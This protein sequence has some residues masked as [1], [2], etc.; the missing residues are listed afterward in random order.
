M[1]ATAAHPFA[2]RARIWLG[3]T[4]AVVTIALCGTASHFGGLAHTHLPA[5]LRAAQ[6]DFS[7]T[8]VFAIAFA[9]VGALIVW[10]RP[11]NRIGWVCCAIGLLWGV[12]EFVLGYFS[13]AAYAPHP[14]IPGVHLV[15]WLVSWIWV[16][17]VLLTFVLLPFLFPDGQ[18]VSPRWWP[19]VWAAVASMTLVA[20]GSITHLTVLSL[21][22]QFLSLGCAV[23][24]PVTLVIRYRR[25]GPDER[26]Q[27]KWFAGAALLLAGLAVAATVVSVLVYHSPDVVFN[28]VGGTVLPLGLT[29]LAAA[30]GISVL[31]YQLYDIGLFLRRALV[32]AALV[33]LIGVLYLVLVV[34][35]GTRI[36][37]PTTDRAIPFVVAA[38]L[39]LIFQPVRIRLQRLA[40][41]L[42][43]GKRASPY[44]VLATFSRHMSEFN[45][46]EDLTVQMARVLAGATEAD[47]ADVWL[48]V[49]GELRL[50]ASW[51]AGDDR[52]APLPLAS[53]E[54][55]GIPGAAIA[56]PV[57]YQEELLG[58]LAVLKR[59][60]LTPIETRLVTDLAHEAGLMLKNERLAAELRQRLDELT[61]SRQRLVTAQDTERR[62]IERNLHDGAQQDLVALKLKLAAAQAIAERDPRQTQEILAGLVTDVSHAVETLRELARGIYPAVLADF[63]LAAALQAQAARSPLPVEVDAGGVGRHPLEVEAAV[64]FCCLEALQNAVKHAQAGRVLISVRERVGEL[65]FTVTDY[66]RGI[67]PA[68]AR[69]GSGIQNMMDRMAALGGSLDL[70]AGPGGGTQVSGRLPV[71]AEPAVT[72]PAASPG[73]A[74]PAG[75]PAADGQRP[76]G[77]AR[78]PIPS[79]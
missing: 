40:N 73:P 29:A 63:G 58:T 66:G 57:R 54:P 77:A 19:L 6:S 2:A 17:P 42:V 10:R 7:L 78:P 44:E 37:A 70:S 14:A 60:D 12:E 71:T 28:P 5:Q 11:A 43:Y 65:C 15:E 35:V 16:L 36:G 33:V 64:Y 26:K 39:A 75:P 18:P 51:P 32:Y 31:R 8:P 41:R 3:W 62:R 13:Y 38:V 49:G 48:R 22:G 59:E 1:T 23:L 25:A 79:S 72:A 47:R 50:A 61:V 4:V 24:A 55:P 53:G 56:V 45:A 52:P 27:I 69:T 21:T 74:G 46:G 67:D 9:I 20:L 68:A 34:S 76:A 30:I